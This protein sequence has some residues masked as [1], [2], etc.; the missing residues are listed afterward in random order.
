MAYNTK[1][2]Y[3]AKPENNKLDALTVRI[4]SKC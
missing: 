1:Q 3:T 4:N 2:I